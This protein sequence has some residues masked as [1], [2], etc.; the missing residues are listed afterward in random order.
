MSKH[1]AG[2][3]M[4]EEHDSDYRGT[5]VIW[6]INPQWE[7]GMYTPRHQRVIAEVVHLQT[8]S[9]WRGSEGEEFEANARLIA[10]APELLGAL[11]GVLAIADR[12][13]KE[14]D[15]A[16]AVIAKAEGRR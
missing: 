5:G 11:K 1:T 14:F 7:P 10:A 6:S 3:W 8:R 9:P 4:H 13:T 12:K 16:R 2:P 15:A